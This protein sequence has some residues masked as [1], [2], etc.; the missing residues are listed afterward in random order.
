M[1]INIQ[2]KEK[3]KKTN[4]KERKETEGNITTYDQLSYLRCQNL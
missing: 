4:K 3:E 2:K 1:V